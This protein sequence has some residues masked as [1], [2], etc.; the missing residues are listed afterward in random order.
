VGVPDLLVERA[1]AAGHRRGARPAARTG[2]D[3]KTWRRS[4]LAPGGMSGLAAAMIVLATVVAMEGLAWASHKYVMHGFGWGWH[5][6]HHQPHGERFERNDLYALAGAAMSIAMFALGSPWLMGEAAWEPG[7]WIGL[8]IL[9]YGVIY[10]LGAPARLRQAAGPG[11]Q[12]PPCD[13]HKGR[14]GELRLRLRARSG[15]AQG[16]APAAAGG[17]DRGRSRE[18]RQLTSPA[19]R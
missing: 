15:Q 18:R 11:A 17:G 9:L 7:T 2:Q 12:A 5:R 19:A 16:G 8:G 4:S 13:H 6:D 14:R 1:R 3:G 10:T